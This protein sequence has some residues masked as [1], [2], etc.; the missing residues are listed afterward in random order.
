MVLDPFSGCGTLIAA[1]QKL[2]R[3]WIGIDITHLA[4]TM[5]KSR[6]REMFNREPKRD[7]LVIGEPEDLSGALQLSHDDRYQFQWW[8]LSLIKV[9]RLAVMIKLEKRFRSGN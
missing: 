5:H 7:Y 9:G 1:A 2:G 3:H 8:A 4:I 6:L